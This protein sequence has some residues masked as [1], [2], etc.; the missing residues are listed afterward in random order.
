MYVALREM[1]VGFQGK[2][3]T[4][5][6]GE[7]VP[8]ADSFNYGVMRANLDMGWMVKVESPAAVHTQV[9]VKPHVNKRKR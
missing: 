9:E 1:K 6:K 2:T 5:R 3:I 8:G 7:E 4:V